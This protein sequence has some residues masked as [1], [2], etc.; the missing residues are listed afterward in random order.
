MAREIDYTGLDY[1]RWSFPQRLFQ[2]FVRLMARLLT[3]TEVEGLDNLPATGPCILAPNH[4]HMFDIPI[5]FCSVS[6]RTVVFAADK[7]QRIPVVGW[8]LSRF[9]SAIY[10]A[11]GEADRRA[12]AQALDV[13][14]A[15]GVLAVA[16][17]GTRS[18]SGGLG[19]GHTGI[20]Y[21]ATRAPAPIL[22]VVAFGQEKAFDHWKRLRRVP[23]K[24]RFGPLM[25][26]PPGKQRMPQLQAYTE[27]LMLELAR[28]LPPAYR[29]IY[30][31]QLAAETGSGES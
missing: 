13:L 24:V 18:R 6:R 20:A 23:V 26:L 3:R 4:L 21:L 5:V 31:E 28:L 9:G 16:P 8:I 12:L 30:A 17:E 29:G 7:W 2:G 10:V 27:Q 11:R 1:S 19:K 15:G 14:R 22:P 25:E